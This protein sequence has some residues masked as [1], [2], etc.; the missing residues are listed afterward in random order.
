MAF[1]ISIIFDSEATMLAQNSCTEPNLQV[2]HGTHVK[3][4]L[5]NSLGKGGY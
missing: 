1:A 4:A 3:L 5:A 2:L